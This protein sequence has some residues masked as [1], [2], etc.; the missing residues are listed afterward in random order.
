MDSLGNIKDPMGRR[1]PDTEGLVE[2]RRHHHHLVCTINI[3]RMSAVPSRRPDPEATCTEDLHRLRN[4]HVLRWISRIYLR[5]EVWP[6][7]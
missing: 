5:V 2:D 4:K 3:H 7:Q 6:A 1:R